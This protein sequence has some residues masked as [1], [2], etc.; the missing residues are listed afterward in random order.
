MSTTS[1]MY[2]VVMATLNATA[3]PS[4]EPEPEPESEPEP[5]PEMIIGTME[6][7]P[8]ITGIL[9]GEPFPEFSS[10]PVAEPEPTMNF[11]AQVILALIAAIILVVGSIGNALVIAVISRMKVDRTVTELFLLSLA[12]ADLFVCVICTPLIIIGITVHQKHTG[13]SYIVEQVMFYF[14]SV[15]SILSLSAIALDRH[16]A[17]IHPM[18]R[19]LNIQRSKQVLVVIWL[20]SSA[21]AVTIYFI[22]QNYE[23]GV[24]A[25]FFIVPLVFMVACYY[26]IV[27]VARQSAS[28]VRRASEAGLK[29]STKTPARTDKTLRMVIIVLVIFVISWVPS[30]ISRLLKYTMPMTEGEKA[31]MEVT[32]CLIAY[33]GSALNFVVYAFMSRRFQ[34]GLVTLLGCQRYFNRKVDIDKPK[35]DIGKTCIDLPVI[36]NDVA[37][38]GPTMKTVYTTCSSSSPRSPDLNE[39][40]LL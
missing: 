32:A 8:W 3:E 12:V 9:F 1:I 14:S 20:I 31:A 13:V 34:R 23:F 6:P 29:K 24:L 19:R 22:P 38:V 2:S 33:A 37:D 21:A 10:E 36:E 18:S 39:K 27:R 25:V 5:E 4:S 11:C 30:L 16:D 15:A 35:S 7:E 26:R 17:V 28:R 40:H